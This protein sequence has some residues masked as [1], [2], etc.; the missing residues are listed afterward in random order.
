MKINLISSFSYFTYWSYFLLV[1]DNFDFVNMSW[2][3]TL[4]IFLFLRDPTSDAS[5]PTS[6]CS[7]TIPLFNVVRTR[8]ISCSLAAS[9]S[10]N[11]SCRVTCQLSLWSSNYLSRLTKVWI[12]FLIRFYISNNINFMKILCLSIVG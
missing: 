11:V 12:M 9:S 1:I 4:L 10:L 6:G 7:V 3:L 8:S 2:L 5:L